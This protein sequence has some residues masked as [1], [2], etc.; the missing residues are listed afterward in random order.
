MIKCLNDNNLLCQQKYLQWM[1]S[2][3]QYSSLPMVLLKRSET[4]EGSYLR[5]QINL[6]S[7]SI[8]SSYSINM[9]LYKTNYYS[10]F[11]FL[12]KNNKPFFSSFNFFLAFMYVKRFTLE[13]NL[14]TTTILTFKNKIFW[15][16]RASVGNIEF[17]R[18]LLL[19][20]YLLN[21]Q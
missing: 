2:F 8:W 18:A 3:C 14:T 9:T 19:W 12:N 4:N 5:K 17:I 16:N 13:S 15:T 1:S 21:T 11:G 20:V 10:I 6:W 7:F